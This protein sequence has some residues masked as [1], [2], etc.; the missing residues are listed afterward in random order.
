MAYDR[1]SVADHEAGHAAALVILGR[2]PWRLTADRPTDRVWGE[3]EQAPYEEITPESVER[4]VTMLHCGPINQGK[5]DW[6]PKYPGDIGGE[7]DAGQLA[8]C[9]RYLGW[10]RAEYDAAY[11][12]AVAMTNTEEFKA[13][14]R[15]IARGLVLK[16]TLFRDDLRKLLGPEILERYGIDSPEEMENENKWNT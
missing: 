9:I 10:G 4:M 5:K 1:E 13:L 12:E 8:A 15:R 6:P 11:V 14:A 3:L 2:L 7:G 16:D